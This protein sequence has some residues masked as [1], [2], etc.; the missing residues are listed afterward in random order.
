MFIYFFLSETSPGVRKWCVLRLVIRG[1]CVCVCFQKRA[2]RA[3]GRGFAL[4][5]S[6]LNTADPWITR[7][8]AA[9]ETQ[10]VSDRTVDP[11]PRTCLTSVSE[12]GAR[13]DARSVWLIAASW[14]RP[15]WDIKRMLDFFIQRL[16]GDG[17]MFFFPLP[18]WGEIR[19]IPHQED[20]SLFCFRPVCPKPK[21]KWSHQRSLTQIG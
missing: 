4:C 6:V 2:E 3:G 16:K 20:R 10:P 14:T 21:K 19:W 1:V 9:E 7:A 5:A 13:S 12:T 11:S 15:R 17:V 18:T 8:K